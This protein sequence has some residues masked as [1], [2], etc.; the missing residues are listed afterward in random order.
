MEGQT[1]PNEAQVRVA[2]IGG[3]PA[4]VAAAFWLTAPEQQ[5]RYRIT[6]Y[7]QGWR[8][9]GKCASGR[10]KAKGD[11]IEEHGLH[12]L[13]GCYQ[14]AFA[15]LRACYDDW[16][17]A[18]GSP[19]ATLNQ[20]FI[21]QRKITL[22]EPDGR[23]GRW[24]SWDFP[25][26]PQLPGEPGDAYGA[27]PL[28]MVASEDSENSMHALV[29]KLA[30][31]LEQSVGA[32]RLIEGG[33]AAIRALRAP[34][35]DPTGDA[36]K[37]KINVLKTANEQLRI[38]IDN[39]K[40]GRDAIRFESIADAGQ[41]YL[42]LANLG[43][44]I[45]LGYLRDIALQ[46]EGAYD[47]LNAQDFRGWLDT[48]GAFSE[49]LAAA[50]IRAIYDLAFAFPGGAA[51]NIDNGSMAAGVTYRFVMEVTF[52]YRN[53]PLW[54]MAA[55]TGD[56]IFTPLYQVLEARQPGC[57]KFFSRF[58]DMTA[59]P[60]GRIQSI[61]LS[62][63]AVTTNGA[64]YNPL[65]SVNNL[66]CWP[67]QPNWSQL[68]NGS[69]LQ[70]AKVNFESSF[71]TVSVSDPLILEVDN[72]F[73][74]VILAIPPAAILKTPASFAQSSARWQTA[75]QGATSVATQSLQLWMSPAVEELGW[76][77]G[78]TVLTAFAQHYDS[79]GEMSHQK[80]METWSGPNAPKAIGY[81]VGCLEVPQQP[82]PTPDSMQQVVTQ[83]A[84]R[85]MAQSLPTLWPNYASSLVVS[86]YGV[87]N[88]DGSDLYVL[89]PGGANVTNRFSSTATAGFSNLY[90][91]G[92]WTRTRYSGG[93]FESAIESAMLASRAISG[94]P[95]KIKTT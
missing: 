69:V 5:N 43:F 40:K 20:A 70:Q 94:F 90:V 55:G 61:N 82:Q 32:G 12:M 23:G 48:C 71:C 72:H 16:T 86:R 10:N 33:A 73:D 88:F 17:P 76:T 21:P 46:G 85:W 62:I 19:I 11:R 15:T 36:T 91:V 6:L 54:K 42:I 80:S 60:D 68:K 67:N 38:A 87:A 28:A 53:A 27:S 59:G 31:W 75:L 77:L 56:T 30:D 26:L 22:M 92:D 45:G 49:T 64:P 44:S 63:Q 74:L 66:Q 7:T 41:R 81:F 24:E 4:G 37:E 14:N 3:G 18:P 50:P 78:P 8:L 29:L 2:I 93:C 84:D 25:G 83:L 9:G 52:G 13:M 65:V 95:A 51:H 58:V 35:A 34:L 39:K 47:R 89:T 1:M 57:V 79:W